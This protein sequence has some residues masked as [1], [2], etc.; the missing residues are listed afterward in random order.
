MKPLILIASLFALVTSVAAQTAVHTGPRT[1]KDN[2]VEAN[3]VCT[4]QYGGPWSVADYP[5]ANYFTCTG[6]PGSYY[7]ALPWGLAWKSIVNN[8]WNATQSGSGTAHGGQKIVAY[9]SYYTITDSYPSS[10][11]A[12]QVIVPGATTSSATRMTVE[13]VT[14]VITFRVED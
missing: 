14:N 6:D 10:Q 4:M 12:T 5:F 8:Q 9:D 13:K 2:L 1:K 7:D 11:N 3:V